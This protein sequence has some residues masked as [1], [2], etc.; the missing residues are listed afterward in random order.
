MWQIYE[1]HSV[2]TTY[3]DKNYKEALRQLEAE[4]RITVKPPALDRRKVKGEVSFG[5]D[6]LVT[7]P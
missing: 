6:V 4:G 2:D 3:N 5:N 1:R 7:F